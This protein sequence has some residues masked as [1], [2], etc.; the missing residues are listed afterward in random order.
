MKRFGPESIARACA[1]HPWRTLGAWAVVL[2]CAAAVTVLYLGGALSNEQHFTNDPESSRATALISESFPGNDR[3]REIVIVRSAG[4]TVDDP[5]FREQVQAVNA[6][7]MALGP[8][9]SSP[10]STTPPTPPR[11][12]YPPTGTRRSRSS[13]WR[14]PPAAPLRTPTPSTAARPFGA[15]RR[16]PTFE[17]LVTGE[18]SINSDFGATA[19]SDL[20]TGEIFG[21][22]IALIILVLVF[23]A[24]VTAPSP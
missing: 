3:S 6:A 23:G 5:Q 24:I 11:Y 16:P 19:E 1:R 14:L 18:A 17:V 21:V 20:R 13:A 15:S 4:L 8:R 10:A 9:W 22:G 7:V 2:V 12:S